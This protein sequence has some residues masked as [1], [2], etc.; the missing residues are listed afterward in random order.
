MAYNNDYA[1]GR[2]DLFRH[3][4]AMRLITCKASLLV[5]KL[6]AS[7]IKRTYKSYPAFYIKW[8]CN[9]GCVNAADHFPHSQEQDPPL[10]GWAL[11]D[12]PEI[13]APTVPVA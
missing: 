2:W 7:P 6:H 3:A 8:I 5:V 10:W 12:M 11:R 9:T 4:G 1:D 13:K